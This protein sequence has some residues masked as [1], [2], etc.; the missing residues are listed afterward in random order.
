MDLY[1]QQR[2]NRYLTIL[3]IGGLVAV[4]AGLGYL[5]DLYLAWEIGLAPGTMPTLAATGVSLV[6]S[7]GAAFTGYFHGDRLVLGATRARPLDPGNLEEKQFQNLVEEVCVA[8]G[9][10]PPRLYV[11]P[12]DDPNAFATG[13]SPEHASIAVTEGLL[14]LL[15]REE[16]MAVVAHEL[17]HIRNLDIRTMTLVSV[18]LGAVAL[19]SDMTLRSM[20]FTGRSAGR[21]RGGG[22][23]VVVAMILGA[24][25]APL[26]ARIAAL[27]VSRT[28]EYEADRSAAELTRNPAALASALRKL[29]SQA[30]PTR[31]ATNGAAHLF[32]VDPRVSK[33]NE[34]EDPLAN[35]LA[36][37][38]PLRSRISRLDRLAYAGDAA[39]PEAR[40]ARGFKRAKTL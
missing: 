36:T 8:A 23:L 37:H 22:L 2:R 25:L 11:L 31:V 26:V 24:V 29:E 3:L 18:L 17:G 38:P 10:P 21:R 13:R 32:I 9:L 27:A 20:R 14:R 35:L 6:F 16:T 34:R 40:P 5:V 33:L 30:A 15:D 39:G 28:R 4:F 1:A 19:L 12:D 7:L